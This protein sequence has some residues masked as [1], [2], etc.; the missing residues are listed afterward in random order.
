[1]NVKNSYGIYVHTWFHGNFYIEK[2]NDMVVAL[3]INVYENKS[4]IYDLQL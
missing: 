3:N 4:S 1:M 2:E